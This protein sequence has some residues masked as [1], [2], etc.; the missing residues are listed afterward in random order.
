VTVDTAPNVLFL[1]SDQH[2]HRDLSCRHDATAPVDTPTLDGIAE[3]GVDFETAYCQ[4]PLCTPS[5]MSFL[6]GREAQRCGAWENWHRLDPDIPTLPGTFSEAG[7]D[8]CLVGKMHLGGDRQFAGFDHRPYGD[9]T[10]MAGH[11]H[12]PP[13]PGVNGGTDPGV[14]SIPES[15]HQERTVVD[16]SLAWLR[17]HRH[18]DPERPWFLCASF[19]RPHPPRTAPARYFE[20]FWPDGVTEPPIPPGAGPDH[21]SLEFD[22]ATGE[23]LLRRRAGYLACVEYLDEILGDFLS[24]LE[25]DGLLENTIVVYASDHGELAG[26]RG[27]F[28]KAEWT[29]SSTRVPL[30]VQT[31]A[32]REGRREPTTVDTPVGLVD[33]FPT[34][35]GLCGVSPPSGLDG[36]DLSGAIVDG[37]T[38]DR[39]P[40]VSDYLTT[41][42]G[43][44]EFR[45]V[46]DGRYKYVHFAE[47]EDLLFDL[48]DDPDETEN[49]FDDDEHAAARS[50]LRSAAVDGIDWGA[51][52]AARRRDEEALT[53]HGLGVPGTTDLVNAYHMPDGRIVSGDAPLYAPQVIAEDPAL[54]YSDFPDEDGA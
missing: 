42:F 37:T 10:G 5:R 3:S 18:S 23:E 14:T 52:R 45:M 50:R 30:F 13:K 4:V 6:T 53:E 48:V 16:E 36:T 54:V 47:H 43:R 34:L 21:P 35:C 28:G 2:G 38:P 44:H 41:S 51:V 26:E 32:H 19:S 11:Q 46:R 27:R 49:L 25:A 31:P 15:L 17:R 7:Y 29:E 20:Q 33:L 8:T 40:V 24:L 9:L 22:P 12:E 1:C 39:G